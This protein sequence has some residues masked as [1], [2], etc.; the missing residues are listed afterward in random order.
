MVGKVVNY[1]E[2]WWKL[3]KKR[4]GKGTVRRWQKGRHQTCPKRRRFGRVTVQT[5]GS[6]VGAK[7]GCGR[8]QRI[9]MWGDLEAGRG[10]GAE[11]VGRRQ[12][13]V[14]LVIFS[15]VVEADRVGD[16]GGRSGRGS[17]VE[18][19]GRGSRLLCSWAGL[20]LWTGLRILLFL[21]FLLIKLIHFN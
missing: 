12:N 9:A 13:D 8:T 17:R 19:P 4:L 16:P 3:V 15:R 11:R 21:F 18:Q 14:V 1:W 7:P 10:S 2:K 6:W 5:R 20:R